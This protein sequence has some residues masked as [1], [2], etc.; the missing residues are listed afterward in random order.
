MTNQREATTAWGA[1]LTAVG[2]SLIATAL[3]AGPAQA[4]GSVDHAEPLDALVSVPTTEVV[5]LPV[6]TVPAPAPE[7]DPE[8]TTRPEVRPEGRDSSATDASSPSRATPDGAPAEVA[9]PSASAR[10]RGPAGGAAAT[11]AIA[12]L[13]PAHVGSTNPGFGVGTCPENTQNANTWGWHFILPGSPSSNTFVTLS[14]TFAQAGTITTFI[15]HPGPNHAYV[16]TPTGDTLLGAT[17]TVGGTGSPNLSEFNLS[18][19]CPGSTT[20]T[21]TAPTTMTTPTTTTTA[22][23]TTTTTTAPTTT[24]VA[25]P[26]PTSTTAVSPSTVVPSSAPAPT[27]VPTVQGDEDEQDGDEIGGASSGGSAPNDSAG[28][29]ADAGGDGLLARTGTDAGALALI[30]AVL[31]VGGLMLYAPQLAGA[32]VSAAGAQ[33]RGQAPR[34]AP[35]SGTPSSRVRGLAF[36]A[37]A[38]ACERVLR[39]ATRVDRGGRR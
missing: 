4:G 13:K 7:P 19:V 38:L 37:A 12:T 1:R 24:V 10:D 16:Y 11:P 23:T 32:R 2:A 21:T 35:A 5:D 29:S 28:G 27:T 25:G 18:H 8:S 36:T 26:G 33:V 15:S 17:A 20:T 22:P 6:V 30:G 9:E 31:M 3:L 39:R 34:E 14:A